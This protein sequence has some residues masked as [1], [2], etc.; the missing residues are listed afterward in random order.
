MDDDDVDENNFDVEVEEE[1]TV[2]DGKG[3]YR[4]E[5]VKRTRRVSKSKIK[6]STKGGKDEVEIEYEVEEDIPDGKGGF[7]K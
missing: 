7:K 2:S 3:G 6:T 4:K 5:L 1:I